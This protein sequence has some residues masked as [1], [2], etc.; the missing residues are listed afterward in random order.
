MVKDAEASALVA[1]TPEQV[2]RALTDP[3]LVKSYFFGT[4]LETDWEIGS[5]ISYSGEFDGK[6]YR[7]KGFVLEYDRPRRLVTSFFSPS[8]GKEDVAENY[9]KVSYEI[10][11]VGDGSQ[12]TITQDNNVSD[13]AAD[14]SSA[15]WQ[16]I[17]DG[18]AKVAPTA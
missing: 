9:Q 2:W 13:D 7:D 10:V 5:P 12:V 16:M 6:A 11:P 15:N 14:H 17:L 3:T 4:E 1:A 18:L 8:S